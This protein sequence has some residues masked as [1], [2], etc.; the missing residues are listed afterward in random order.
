M[1]A[2]LEI[3]IMGFID[4]YYVDYSSI[5]KAISS[6][7]SILSVASQVALL[8]LLYFSLRPKYTTLHF[9]LIKNRWG[10]IYED[11]KLFNNPSSLYMGYYFV[12]RRLIYGFFAIFCN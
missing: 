9:D 11:L 8:Y 5:G 1:E 2:S 6:L 3:F 7:L 12:I 4:L 10:A